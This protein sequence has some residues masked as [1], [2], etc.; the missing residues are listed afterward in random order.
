MKKPAFIEYEDSIK[1]YI[2]LNDIIY[3]RKLYNGNAN[4]I[5][6]RGVIYDIKSYKN[7]VQSIK[8]RGKES[9][10]YFQEIDIK[11]LN[12]IPANK[13]TNIFIDMNMIDS[14]IFI[15]MNMV[16]EV[17]RLDSF[18]IK[19]SNRFYFRY[20][21]RCNDGS[22]RD[23]YNIEFYQTESYIESFFNRF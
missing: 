23:M 5:T 16:F 22:G 3:I 2:N 13:L 7:I 11:D 9:E 12:D 14:S 8:Y 19:D 4:I 17:T 18:H 20:I 1:H 10:K 21:I 15:D 6:T